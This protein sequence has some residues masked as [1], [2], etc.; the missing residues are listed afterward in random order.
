MIGLK[1]TIIKIF[2]SFMHNFMHKHKINTI[3]EQHIL[4]PKIGE[5]RCCVYKTL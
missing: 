1:Q 2:M 5:K 4:L 3:A